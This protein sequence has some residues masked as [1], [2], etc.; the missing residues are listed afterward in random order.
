MTSAVEGRTDMPFRRAD[1]RDFDPKPTFRAA[2]D[3]SREYLRSPR[4]DPF[5]PCK[6]TPP[7]LG[8][9]ARRERSHPVLAGG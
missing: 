7:A 9:R 8:R 4:T 3:H 6:L 5:R 1:F 2:G